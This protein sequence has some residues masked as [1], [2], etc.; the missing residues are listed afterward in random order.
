MTEHEP[1][2]DIDLEALSRHIEALEGRIG[3]LRGHAAE[4]TSP[5]FGELAIAFETLH[6]AHE[7]LRQQAEALRQVSGWL[8]VERQRYANLFNLAPD[9]YIVTDQDGKIQEVNEAA[10]DLLA[11][12]ANVLAGKPLALYISGQHLPVYAARLAKLLQSGDRQMWE[13]EILPRGKP[14]VP[15]EV[16]VTSGLR[17]GQTETVEVRWR[18]YDTTRRKQAEDAL[19]SSLQAL[20]LLSARLEAV[21]EEERARLSRDLHDEVG[22]TLTAARVEV[23]LAAESLVTEARGTEANR[24]DAAL[25]LIDSAI[26]TTRHIAADLRPPV[27]DRLGL[28]AAIEWQLKDF[29]RHTGVVCELEAGENVPAIS[30]PAAT[31][32]FRMFQ[33][34][35]TN[36]ARH[37]HATRVRVRLDWDAEA[38][39][40]ALQDNGR[41]IRAEDAGAIESLGLVGIRERLRLI[42]GTFDIRATDGGGTLASI[43]VPRGGG[44]FEEAA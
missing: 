29:E 44:N 21:R 24:L 39:Y 9:G 12:P 43:T 27:L 5:I 40:L 13:A 22:S 36:V 42:G 15:V 2:L 1:G 32:L 11:R 30:G 8:E 19:A 34:L 4:E 35:L 31:A 10:A 33:E 28:A 26:D 7:E 14:A 23:A 37:A 38:L 6:V 3:A 18:I 17:A 41:G 20:R 16:A 25:E